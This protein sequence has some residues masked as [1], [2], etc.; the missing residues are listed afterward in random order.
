MSEDITDY[1]YINFIDFKAAFDSINREFIWKAFEYYGLPKKYIN[2]FK[3]FF[4]A[5]ESAVRVNGE[6]TRWFDV[7][8]G[9]GQGDVQGPPIFNLVLNWGLE[10]AEK[11]KNISRGF[12][13]QYRQSS[14]QPEKCAI[15]LDYAD[16][17]AGMDDTVEGLQETILRDTVGLGV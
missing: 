5:T 17:I 4:K 7:D 6:L 1:M 16:N 12:T 8:S 14:R 2:V 11:F 3:A 10:L 13:L 15:D 9:T